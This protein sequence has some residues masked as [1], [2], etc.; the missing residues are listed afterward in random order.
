MGQ[1][2][3]AIRALASTGLAP[4]PLL[5][6][7]DGYVARHR[8]GPHGDRRVCPARR[9]DGRAALRL[10]GPSAADPAH[11]GRRA[12]LSVGW[13]LGAAGLLR[14]GGP[15]REGAARLARGATLLL[16]TDGLVER[17]TQSLDVG[18]AQRLLAEAARQDGDDL[19]AMLSSLV[20]A[21]DDDRSD[22]LCLLAARRTGA[23]DRRHLDTRGA[24]HDQQGRVQRRAVGRHRRRPAADRD[25]GHRRQPR[26][27]R[28]RVR[29][30]RE[31]LRRGPRAARGRVHERPA[32]H[33]T[34]D[35]RQAADSP[36]DL[37][38]Q[39]TSTLREAIA[40]LERVGTEDEVIEYKRYVFSLAESVARA[41]K[42]GGFLGIGAHAESAS[43]S[44]PRSTR[45][46]RSSTRR[47]R[48]PL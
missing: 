8:V 15:R 6:A 17:R 12:A 35:R 27:Q 2:R 38:D 43:P 47:R 10:R 16:Y 29:R 13:A 21:M 36:D 41:H 26:R 33:T 40:I 34:G 28:A 9:G 18:F 5:D 3:S 25:D 32:R 48:R 24:A 19:A 7:L 42:E 4:G 23:A 44:R 14:V 22:D 1:L 30:R 31:D 46:P 37:P 45:S 39:A 11:A 20:S